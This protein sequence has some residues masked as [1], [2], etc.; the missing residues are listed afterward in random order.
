M[1]YRRLG[2]SGLKVAPICL[3][4]MQFGWTA[5]EKMS[6]RIMDAYVEAGGNFIDTAD[7]YSAW[8]PGN[9]GGESEVIIGRWL[10][11]RKNRSLMVVATKLNGRMW[12][13][14]NGEG[15]S[16]SHLMKAVE[17]SLQRLDTDYIDL[18]QN[19]LASPGYSIG[20]DPAC[21]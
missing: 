2:N 9:K 6:F 1:D 17:D 11:Q 8:A 21:P 18:Y 14:P 13:G 5:D 3:G 16:R 4:T 12:E 20:R 15:L 19:S 10:K 7:I